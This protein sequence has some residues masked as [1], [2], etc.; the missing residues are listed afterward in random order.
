MDP[1]SDEVTG[2]KI[3]LAGVLEKN[4]GV[5]KTVEILEHVL[6]EVVAGGKERGGGERTRLLKRGVGVGLKLG[7][8]Y[9]EMGKRGEAEEALVWAVET[10]LR[11]RGRRE[12]EGVEEG[13]GEWLSDE[14]V[15][16]ALENLAGFYGDA[17]QHFLASPLYLQA[18]D[19]LAGNSCHAVVLSMGFLWYW[20]YGY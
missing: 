13:E 18:L 2:I 1:L 6:D 3:E 7:A 16:M 17:D 12:K 15:G 5:E 19:L 20:V 8:L 11:E 9:V 10:V 14:E 4:G